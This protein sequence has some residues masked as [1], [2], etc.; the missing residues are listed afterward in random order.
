MSVV[1]DQSDPDELRRQF[2]QRRLALTTTERAAAA[3]AVIAPLEALLT[4]LDGPVAAYV[5][6]GSEIDPADWMECAR[7]RGAALWLPVLLGSGN[8]LGFRP[9]PD[10]TARWQRNAHGI[11]EPLD[12]PTLAAADMAA[13]VMP[14]LAFDASGTRLG[15]G[16]GYYDRTLAECPGRRPLRI[17][18]AFACQRAEA[19]PRRAWDQPLHHIVTETESLPCPEK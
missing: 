13:L 16:G 4:A 2:R 12:G 19:L 18:L 14:L 9:L 8:A 6:V 15:A 11:P 17:G 3:Q 1:P 10:D 5:A 7:R